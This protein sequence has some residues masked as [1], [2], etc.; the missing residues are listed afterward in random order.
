MQ[1]AHRVSLVLF[2]AGTVVAATSQAQASGALNEFQR[3]QIAQ[4]IPVR[5]V[6]A[7]GSSLAPATA[8]ILRNNATGSDILVVRK[9]DATPRLVAESMH[10]LMRLQD[11]DGD[12]APA[13]KV[14]VV[15]EGTLPVRVMRNE[16]RSAEVLLR[17][18]AATPSSYVAGVG[19]G[20]QV[21]TV[22]LPAK[23]LRDIL[24]REGRLGFNTSRS[25][26]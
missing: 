20:V 24:M 2:S 4:R 16:V 22:F 11:K 7:A 3:A 25:T 9:E 12:F 1:Y 21:A 13:P 15:R 17:R 19:A 23:R 8:R 5:L 18:V 14:V 6:M 26:P 10:I